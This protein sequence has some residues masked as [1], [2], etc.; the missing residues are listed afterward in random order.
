MG[1][2]L[3][4]AMVMVMVMV[5]AVTMAMPMDTGGQL[6]FYTAKCKYDPCRPDVG[7]AGGFSRFSII[8]GFNMRHVQGE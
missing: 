5:M 6:L 7:G 8:D 2:K 4:M 1:N 3:A